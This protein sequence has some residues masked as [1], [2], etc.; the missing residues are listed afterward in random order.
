METVTLTITGQNLGELAAKAMTFAQ[1]AQ[2][3]IKLGAAPTTAQKI[4][5]KAKKA[6]VE[7]EETDLEMADEE[8]VDD[9]LDAAGSDD[10]ALEMGFDAADEDEVEETPKKTAAKT[11]TAKVTE[12]DVNAA[13]LAH[14]RKHTRP[15][16]LELLKKKFKVGSISELK[17]DQYSAVISALKV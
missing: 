4:L 7:A 16:T 11:K 2:E 15:K 6:A 9:T 17:P 5:K 14:A 3:G 8:L 13:C 1:T 12:K 10:E